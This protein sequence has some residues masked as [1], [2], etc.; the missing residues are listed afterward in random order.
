MDGTT[1][2]PRVTTGT[3]WTTVGVGDFDGDGKADILWRHTS[4]EVPIWFMNGT[5]IASVGLLGRV[6]TD[7][8]IAGVGDFNGDGKADIL[9][10]RPVRCSR[11]SNI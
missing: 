8:T 10:Q 1:A 9:W 11:A 2:E 6:G 3:D 5:T 4:R 7:W